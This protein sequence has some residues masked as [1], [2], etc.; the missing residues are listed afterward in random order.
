M[1]KSVKSIA[2]VAH[3][4]Y[5]GGGISVGRNIIAALGQVAPENNYLVSIP[6]GLGYET[7]CNSLPNCQT[8]IFHDKA[9]LLKRWWWEG[10]VL[11]PAV[12]KF[13]PDFVLAL[14]NKGLD[15]LKCPEAILCHN[16]YIWYPPE[17]YGAYDYLELLLVK[18]KVWAQRR[19]LKN[20]LECS[21]NILLHQTH[22]ARERLEKTFNVQ[23][24]TVLC[25]NAVSKFVTFSGQIPPMPEKMRP[26]SGRFKMFCLARYY[27]HKNL[28]AIV[29]VF[30]KYSDDL[31]ECA[32]FLTLSPDQGPGAK[33][34][35]A[36]IDTFRL[37]DQ[38][39]N[40]GPLPQEQLGAW[41]RNAD[42]LLMPTLLESFS[43]TYLEAMHFGTPILTSDLD[44]AR[45]ICA[46]AARYFNPWDLASIR[47][48]ILG[49]RE[50]PEE[51]AMLKDAGTKRLSE[52]QKTWTEIV[53]DI[54]C[55]IEAIH[56]KPESSF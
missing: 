51:R 46:G 2:I 37:H 48:A 31:S 43:G 1:D 25:P 33:K 45:E 16:P 38:L 7:V 27:P 53:S 3:P 47:D 26:Y 20:S 52:V 30:R 44:F 17:R 10:R 6:S 21:R 24:K 41:Y 14:A 11:R 40:L 15:G 19:C 4:L 35:L 49:F 39:I 50:S 42:A 29:E 54:L 56:K 55:S 23:A 28:E 36:A 13:C 18:I 22:T 32:V 34:L 5:A 12:M 8:H 9:N